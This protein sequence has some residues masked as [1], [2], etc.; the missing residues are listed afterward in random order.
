MPACII[1]HSQYEIYLPVSEKIRF[2]PSKFTPNS[3]LEMS[4]FNYQNMT[5]RPYFFYLTKSDIDF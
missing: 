1:R 5:I 3:A 2:F 4:E